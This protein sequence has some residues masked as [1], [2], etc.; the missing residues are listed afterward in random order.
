MN[1]MTAIPPTTP[2]TIAPIGVLFFLL[3]EPIVGRLV[4]PDESACVSVGLLD[5][6]G[7]A[8]CPKPPGMTNGCEVDVSEPPTVTV[9]VAGAV[10]VMEVVPP[11][12]RMR[13]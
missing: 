9:S 1:A 5:W 3:W 2:P 13:V 4:E 7:A 6:V 10:A 12:A 8:P 11:P